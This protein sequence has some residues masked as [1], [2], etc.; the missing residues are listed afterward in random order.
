MG[1][2]CRLTGGSLGFT[3]G[4]G[5]GGEYG[6]AALLGLNALAVPSVLLAAGGSPAGA[7]RHQLQDAPRYLK[8]LNAGVL[9]V[10]S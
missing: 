8:R 9:L 4:L 1:A 5:C 7:A 6:F 2:E 3:G 10:L